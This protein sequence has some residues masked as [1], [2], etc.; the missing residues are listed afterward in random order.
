MNPSKPLHQGHYRDIALSLVFSCLTC[1]FYAIYWNWRQFD[2]LNTLLGREEY[3]FVMWLLLTILTCGL[4][5]VY[6]QYKM[7]GQIAEIMTFYGWPAPKNLQ[8]VGLLLSIIGLALIADAIFQSEINKL[9][10]NTPAPF[11]KS[12]SY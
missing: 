11:P 10:E 8:M 4:Y 9:C 3:N 12:P 7:G 1:G 5:H 6:Y 2:T